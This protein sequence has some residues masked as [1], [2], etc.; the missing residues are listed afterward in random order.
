MVSHN[1]RTAGLTSITF[2]I[3]GPCLS[4]LH[5]YDIYESLKHKIH[6]L[7]VI[8]ANVVELL[9]YAEMSYFVPSNIVICMLY[10]QEIYRMHCHMLETLVSLF[11]EC[12]TV[13]WDF[14]FIKYV[15]KAFC[16]INFLYCFILLVKHKKT[17][18]RLTA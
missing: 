8:T 14:F 13:S 1:S 11:P 15:L 6:N 10:N 12:S 2:Y 16:S 17:M 7:E 4:L 3:E 9:H 5:V 18:T